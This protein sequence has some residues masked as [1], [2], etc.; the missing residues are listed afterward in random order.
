MEVYPSSLDNETLVSYVLY[1]VL[2]QWWFDT[3]K[4]STGTLLSLV[5]WVLERPKSQQV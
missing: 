2:R 1:G 4:R 5:S 3:K